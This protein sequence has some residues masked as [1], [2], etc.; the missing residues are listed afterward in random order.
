MKGSSYRMYE[1][2]KRWYYWRKSMEKR[3]KK[4]IKIIK[5]HKYYK[6]WEK[7]IDLVF[8][9]VEKKILYPISIVTP[10]FL[11]VREAEREEQEK[12]DWDLAIA[13]KVK[14]YIWVIWR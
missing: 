3:I 14:G 9:F 11:K 13:G 7:E 6:K 4:H 1:A 5:K 12:R 2:D 10:F 8:W